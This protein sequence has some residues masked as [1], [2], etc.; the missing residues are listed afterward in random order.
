MCTVDVH[1]VVWIRLVWLRQKSFLAGCCFKWPNSFAVK[2]P[3]FI[4]YSVWQHKQLQLV[5]HSCYNESSD[6]KY[7]HTHT[8][9]ADALRT[10]GSLLSHHC[11]DHPFIPTLHREIKSVSTAGLSFSVQRHRRLR[12]AARPL[13]AALKHVRLLD[14]GAVNG[15]KSRCIVCA[16]RWRWL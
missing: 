16:C 9:T 6:C 5:N 13:N 12:A 14:T 11:S 4:P 7:V 2:C 8:H 1:R 15:A 10:E 3:F